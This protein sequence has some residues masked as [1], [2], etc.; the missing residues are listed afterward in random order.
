VS[1][2]EKIYVI[3]RDA[4]IEQGAVFFGGYATS[5][6]SKYMPLEEQKLVRKIP[7]FDVLSED[8]EKCAAF[9]KEKLKENNV[10]G[11]KIINHKSIGELVPEY[12][13]IKVGKDT[14]AFIYKPIACHSYNEITI[15]E[16]QIKI[17]SI[18]TI[19]AFYLSFIYADFY[20]YYKD[21]LLC[22]A[23]FLFDVESKNRLEQK[24]LLKRFSIK[25]YGKQETLEEIRSKKADKYKEL[26]N[27]KDTKEYEMWF[28]K[29]NPG[30]NPNMPVKT[31]KHIKTRKNKKKQSSKLSDFLI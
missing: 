23:K 10:T 14:I 28:L 21:R 11:V 2:N 12:I 8:N 17:A 15:D 24:G 20:S 4:L 7:D 30:Y 13:Q 26:A 5:L 1:D 19:L 22:M 27:K 31:T 25:C 9:V 3:V 18:D 16:N 6:Y 29:Y